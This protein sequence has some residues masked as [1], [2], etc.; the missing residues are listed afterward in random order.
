[1]GFLHQTS[2]ASSPRSTGPWRTPPNIVGQSLSTVCVS[3]YVVTDTNVA[4]PEA[5]LAALRQSPEA[6]WLRTWPCEPG[7]SVRACPPLEEPARRPPRKVLT[8]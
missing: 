7:A 3:G 2:P 5:T 4:L 1:M 6:I 8:A